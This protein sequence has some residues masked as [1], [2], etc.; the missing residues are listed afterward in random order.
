MR[1]GFTF[2]GCGRRPHCDTLNLCVEKEISDDRNVLRASVVQFKVT[3]GCGYAALVHRPPQRFPLRFRFGII[4]E[5]NPLVSPGNRPV[6][7]SHTPASVDAM[8]HTR[9]TPCFRTT[10]QIRAQG[11]TLDVPAQ[12]G[13]ML[14][15]FP[16]GTI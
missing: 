16:R 1:Q 7:E 9:P 10:D 6:V 12:R 11:V 3:C 8:P 15:F 4:H 14:V 13:E 2:F 5:I